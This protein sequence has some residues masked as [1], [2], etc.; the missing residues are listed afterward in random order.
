MSTFHERGIGKAQ[1]SIGYLLSVLASIGV[2]VSGL[3]KFTQNTWA[4]EPLEKLELSEH[5]IVVGV[6]EVLC[7]LLYWIPKTSNIGFFLLCSYTGGI[8]V[9]E[10]L[11]DEVPVPGMIIGVMVYLG[12]LLRK[13]S[14]SGLSA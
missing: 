10:L 11:M 13:P 9:G 12:T 14:L 4:M 1:K 5:A 2:L 8:I 3:L 7:V 6:V